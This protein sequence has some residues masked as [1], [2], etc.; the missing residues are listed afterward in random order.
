M[1]PLA[2]LVR[3]KLSLLEALALGAL[4]AA[5][6]VHGWVGF[7]IGLPAYFLIAIIGEGIRKSKLGEG[8]S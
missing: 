3:P 8:H 5:S 2:W 6:E 4:V 1:G 7:W